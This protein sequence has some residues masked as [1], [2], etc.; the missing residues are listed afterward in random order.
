LCYYSSEMSLLMRIHRWVQPMLA[1][2]RS[3]YLRHYGDSATISLS[4]LLNRRYLSSSNGDEGGLDKKTI[5]ERVINVL[6]NFDK[7]DPSKVIR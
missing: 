6:K 5:E 7:V 2:R 3:H 1:M 4:G